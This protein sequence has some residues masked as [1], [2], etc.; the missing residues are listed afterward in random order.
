MDFYFD[1]ESFMKYL[2]SNRNLAKK[3]L[4]KISSSY[5]LSSTQSKKIC[6]VEVSY[7][8]SEWESFSMSRDI[9][10]LYYSNGTIGE[11]D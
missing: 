1:Q 8:G 10:E 9:C 2:M 5:R 6:H 4:R 3:H 11:A 7:Q